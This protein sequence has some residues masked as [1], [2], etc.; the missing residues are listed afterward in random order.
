MEKVKK[1][2]LENAINYDWRGH[3]LRLFMIWIPFNQ[4]DQFLKETEI[5]KYTEYNHI[6]NCGLC[7]GLIAVDL[8]ECFYEEDILEYFPKEG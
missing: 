5:M 4:I 8:T 2:I 6:N 7:E 3:Q 1:F